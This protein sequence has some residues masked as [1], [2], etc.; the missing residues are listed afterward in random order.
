MKLAVIGSRT[1]KQ[2]EVL[3][4]IAQ[5]VGRAKTPVTE[6]ITGG[7]NGV[8]A[9]AEYY[10]K[11]E[12]IKMTVFYPQYQAHGRRAPLIRNNVII[13]EAEA[14]LAIWD[15]ESSGTRYTIEKAK[16]E[17]LKVMVV[18]LSAVKK[19]HDSVWSISHA[20]RMP[21][22]MQTRTRVA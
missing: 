20:G 8:D 18:R 16:R 11:T 10:A 22:V 17:G 21:K 12:G 13:E 5:V 4:V 3:T 2:R 19:Y 7:A 15:G 6:I 9:I 14:M 1:L